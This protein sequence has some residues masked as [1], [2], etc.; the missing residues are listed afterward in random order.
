MHPRSWDLL[1]FKFVVDIELLLLA[2]NSSRALE[3][4]LDFKL[5]QGR[6]KIY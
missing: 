2:Y 4:K 3:T 6:L 1:D 5:L